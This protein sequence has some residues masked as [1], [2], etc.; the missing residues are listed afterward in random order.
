MQDDPAL[1]RSYVADGSEAAFASLVQRHIAL[2]YSVALRRVGG[3]THL[4]QDVTQK[5]FVNLARK[6]SALRGHA[7]LSGWLYV[8]AQHASAELVRREQRRKH[9]ETTAHSMH[10]EN[11][12]PSSDADV[13]KLRPVIDD[14]IVTLKGDE[15]N[16][17]ILR[18]FEKRTFAEIGADLLVTE[19]AAR[20]RVDRAL[21]KLNATLA[22]RGITSTAA[23]LGLALSATATGNVPLGLATQISNIALAQAG[24][25]TA[26]VFATVSSVGLP[27]VALAVVCTWLILPQQRANESLKSEIA[28]LS[29]SGQSLPALRAGNDQLSRSVATARDLQRSQA[30]L[31]SVRSAHAAP[32]P[33]TPRP[34]SNSLTLTPKGTIAWEGKPVTLDT[35][36]VNLKTLETSAPG[37]ES[38]LVIAAKGVHI[39]QLFYVIDEARKAGI[40][41]ILVDSDAAPEPRASWS[42]F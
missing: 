31:V 36:L 7:S 23:A 34:T 29:A 14:A 9:R 2:V 12:A 17:I 35:Y 26:S 38:K 20:K 33:N 13:A 19:E 30:Y 16:A 5:V 32:T 8:T 41:H 4:A 6:A 40:K 11:S 28:R 24:T 1:L 3:D 21:E 18:F 22:R 15:R 42:W 27:A 39:G 37:G 25:A 10:F